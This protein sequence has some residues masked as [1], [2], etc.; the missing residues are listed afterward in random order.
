MHG[1]VF[2]ELQKYAETKHGAGTWHQLLTRAGLGNKLY[3][4]VQE[5]PDSEIASLVRAAS[6]I[7]GQPTLAL[8]EDFG[9][10]IVPSLLRMYGHLLKPGWKSIDVIEHTEGTVHT[11]V[12]VQNPGAKPPQ[13]MSQ[14]LSNNE[15]LMIYDSPRRMCALAIGIA[16]GLALHYGEHIVIREA[17]CMHRGANRCE[18]LFRTIA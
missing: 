9:Q 8:L 7:T 13:L 14:R 12:R 17:I 2:A 5:Y 6:E 3:F 15:V 16:K 4:P 10:F 1:I 11:V 18:I